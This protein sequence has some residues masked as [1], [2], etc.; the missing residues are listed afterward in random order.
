MRAGQGRPFPGARAPGCSPEAEAPTRTELRPTA[1]RTEVQGGSPPPCA[2]QGGRT[3]G[4]TPG[5]G[6]VRVLAA[7]GVGVVEL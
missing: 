6:A 3:S 2:L 7:Q 4:T 1:R 5:S